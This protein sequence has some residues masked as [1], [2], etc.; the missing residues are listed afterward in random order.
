MRQFSKRFVTRKSGIDIDTK[1]LVH[2][3][4]EFWSKWGAPMALSED[5]VFE[6]ISAEN[7]RNYN[8]MFLSLLE[9]YG[10]PKTYIDINQSTDDF[11]KQ[12]NISLPLETKGLINR[13]IEETK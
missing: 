12:V 6:V 10:G 4:Y 13:I 7:D 8:S 2:V 11:L 5:E 9:K 1:K 3:A